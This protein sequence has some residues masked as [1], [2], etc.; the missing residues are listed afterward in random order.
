M[1]T[2]EVDITLECGPYVFKW[3]QSFRGY[4]WRTVINGVSVRIYGISPLVE[5]SCRPGSVNA[6]F[7]DANGWEHSTWLHFKRAR[8]EMDAP[9]RSRVTFRLYP[10]STSEDIQILIDKGL[11]EMLS[12]T[13]TEI[14]RSF[15]RRKARE[16]K[17]LKN[18]R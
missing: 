2:F 5:I 17:R 16:K 15:R 7:H 13:E 1:A 9:K 11:S 12:K 3:A 18:S 6:G 10:E 4:F 14:A 8:L